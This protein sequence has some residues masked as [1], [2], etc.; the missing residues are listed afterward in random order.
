MNGYLAEALAQAMEVL[1]SLADRIADLL[2]DGIDAHARRAIA[3]TMSG[4]V[5]DP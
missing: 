5:S 2:P 1:S 4:A 3:R